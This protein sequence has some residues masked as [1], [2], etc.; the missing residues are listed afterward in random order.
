[1][2]LVGTLR[3]PQPCRSARRMNRA[4]ISAT[5]LLLIGCSSQWSTNEEY[6]DYLASIVI[7]YQSKQGAVPE[8]FENAHNASNVVLPNRGDK[9]GRTL[10]YFNFPPDAFMFRSYGTNQ[11]D[12]LGFEDDL[13]VYYI[14]TKK[15]NR[16]NFISH[17]KTQNDPLQWEAF[18][19]VFEK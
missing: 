13:D 7:D 14:K 11:K 10:V 18:K 6:L 9:Y 12:D 3:A 19:T 4:L 8:S 2:G 16:S 17:I 1:M 15:T 5:C